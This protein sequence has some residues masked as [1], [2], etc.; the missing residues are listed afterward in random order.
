M[1][2]VLY[3]FGLVTFTTSIGY[4]VY[5]STFVENIKGTL[6]ELIK[7]QEPT[8]PSQM[9]HLPEN[10]NEHYQESLVLLQQQRYQLES[11]IEQI[12]NIEGNIQEIRNKL[13]NLK[14]TQ[15]N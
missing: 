5:K 10:K 3:Y 9:E 13:E 6:N 8:L 14:E 4:F 12:S 11:L 1:S 15:I 2:K 7:R